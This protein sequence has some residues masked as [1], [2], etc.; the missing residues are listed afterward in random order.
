MTADERAELVQGHLKARN[1]CSK[2]G[3]GD[4]KCLCTS[5]NETT[6]HSSRD[7]KNSPRSVTYAGMVSPCRSCALPRRASSA[8]RAVY[9]IQGVLK[10][11]ETA[12]V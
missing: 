9:Q 10:R 6:R 7:E 4:V 2:V 3:R 1:L 8:S 12:R 5:H 11:Q